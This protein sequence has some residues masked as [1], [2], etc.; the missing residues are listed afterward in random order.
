MS[1]EFNFQSQV[2]AIPVFSCKFH[3]IRDDFAQLT[4]LIVRADSSTSK[5]HLVVKNI[6]VRYTKLKEF[7]SPT[8]S[9]TFE[10]WSPAR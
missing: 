8:W 9:P 1:V 5:L 6:K 3:S 4:D 7:W 10:S 2:G